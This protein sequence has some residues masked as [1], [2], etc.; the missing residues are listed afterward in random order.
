M[1]FVVPCPKCATRLR[2]ATWIDTGHRLKCPACEASFTTRRPAEPLIASRSRT[3]DE[4]PDA[5]VL[6]D[7]QDDDRPSPRRRR[8]HADAEPGRASTPSRKK[9]V[10]P[11]LIVGLTVAVFVVLLGGGVLVYLWVRDG[12]KPAAND[13]FAHA[14]TDAVAL[15]G[16]DFEELSRHDRFRKA[17]DTRAPAD[18]VELDRSGFRAAD[19][20]R[21]LV[22]R[23][24]QNGNTCAV[25][26]KAPPD[27]SKYLQGNLPGKNYAPFTSA[28]SSYRFGYFA[29]DRT[30][31]LAEREPTIQGILEKGKKARLPGD[32]QAMV[33]KARGPMWRVTGKAT[34]FDRRPAGLWP[35]TMEF[36]VGGSAGSAVWLTPDGPLAKVYM[37]LAFDNR[38]QALQ[39]AAVLRSSFHLQR[40]T[41]EYGLQIGRDGTDPA[42]VSDIRRGY[43]EASV[44]EDGNRVSARLTLPASEA[45]RVVGAVR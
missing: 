14:P 5:V 25:R 23:T 26:F 37:E 8:R 7:E 2:S 36:P 41:N 22:A 44:S 18:V 42:D 34:P 24:A 4:I 12:N 31:V 11:G 17:L 16:V 30:L 27:K 6:D 40:G 10:S 13:L 33:D 38:N 45:M 1:P 43:E 39:G 19:L 9:P 20:A 21:A 28:T 3:D 32:L 35:N 29:D 15:S